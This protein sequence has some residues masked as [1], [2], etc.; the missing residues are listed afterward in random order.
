MNLNQVTVATQNIAESALFYRK[1]GLTQTVDSAHYAR[2]EC[3]DGGST[4]S[5]HLDDRQG[6]GAIVYF[7]CEQL[8]DT[9]EALVRKGFSF[10]QLQRDGPWWKHRL[11]L[12]GGRQSPQPAMAGRVRPAVSYCAA[13]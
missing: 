4:I 10:D 6:S 2:F 13:A 1:L 5:V 3:P 11:S 7:E 8:D 9:C 12:F